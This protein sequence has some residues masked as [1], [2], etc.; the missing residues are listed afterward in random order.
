[1]L[2]LKSNRLFKSRK[3]YKII[4]AYYK[5]NVTP[6]IIPLFMVSHSYLLI[7]SENITQNA[8]SSPA[9]HSIF[10][11]IYFSAAPENFHLAKSVSRYPHLLPGTNK[12]RVHQPDDIVTVIKLSLLCKTTGGLEALVKIP[13]LPL[14]L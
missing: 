11:F 5:L 7:L 1:M 14:K 10:N 13:S 8:V 9:Y 12:G 2:E 6:F 4:K 3:Y